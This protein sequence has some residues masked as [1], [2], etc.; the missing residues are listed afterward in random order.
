MKLDRIKPGDTVT[1]RVRGRTFEA[2]VIARTFDG[3]RIE[4]P[5][6]C[7]HYHVSARQVV[8][9]RHNRYDPA[10]TQVRHA[11]QDS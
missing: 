5:K 1:C 4:P 6:N 3:L 2:Q 7:T 11:G 9:H 8:G 10:R